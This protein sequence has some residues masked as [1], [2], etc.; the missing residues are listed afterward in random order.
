MVDEINHQISFQL[1]M[2]LISAK[3]KVKSVEYH[4]SSLLVSLIKIYNNYSLYFFTFDDFYK[5]KYGN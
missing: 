2:R 3:I 4:F 5:N 1:I